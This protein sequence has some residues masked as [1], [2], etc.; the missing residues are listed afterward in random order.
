M[1]ALPGTAARALASRLRRAPER[2]SRLGETSTTPPGHRIAA[3][4]PW[5]SGAEDARTPDA[6]RLPGV[7]EPREASGV[8]PIY[9]RFPPGLV[10]PHPIPVDL[11]AEAQR[12]PRDAESFGLDERA[13]QAAK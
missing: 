3:C 4:L 7:C 12:R 10:M 13:I 8:R 2:R 1:G 6:S 11:N 9:R 5:E